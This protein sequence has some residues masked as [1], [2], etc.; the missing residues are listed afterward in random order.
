MFFCGNPAP[1]IFNPL[2][3]RFGFD[4]IDSDLGTSDAFMSKLQMMN[5]CNGVCAINVDYVLKNLPALKS[6]RAP[7]LLLVLFHYHVISY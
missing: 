2:N 6:T 5:V 7:Y 3:F 1:S 4:V